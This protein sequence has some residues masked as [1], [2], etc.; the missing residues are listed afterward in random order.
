MRATRGA[1]SSAQATDRSLPGRP[2]SSFPPLGLLSPPNPLR[3]ASAGAPIT[4]STSQWDGRQCRPGLCSVR[5]AHRRHGLRVQ[6]PQALVVFP[7]LLTAKAVRPPRRRALRGVDTPVKSGASGMPRPPVR[8]RG[9]GDHRSPLRTSRRVV[10]QGTFSC[11]VGAIHLVAPHGA[12][13]CGGKG[14]DDIRT[15]PTARAQKIQPSR[16]DRAKAAMAGRK[17]SH[18]V[19]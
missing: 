10:P 16:T 5:T 4:A 11:P 14:A 13:S 9:A 15:A 18:R 12:S 8:R 2:E 7:P 1:A 19:G 17:F 3:W 6:G